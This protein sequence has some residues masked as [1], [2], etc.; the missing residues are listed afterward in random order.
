MINLIR[1]LWMFVCAC[2]FGSLLETLWCLIKERKIKKRKDLIYGYFTSMYGIAGVLIAICVEYFKINNVFIIFFISLV[3][4]AIVEYGSSFIQEKYMGTFSW[5]YSDMKFN[6]NGRINLVYLLVFGL[7]G[8]LWCK[9]Y[10]V[11]S[12]YLDNVINNREIVLIS[13]GI[14][15]LFMLYNVVISFIVGVRQKSRREGILPKNN[16]EIWI[17]N[18]Y[19]DQ[20][21]AKVFPTL[22]FV[23]EKQN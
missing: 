16:L 15:F 11:I 9:G 6:L 22:E 5:D 17:D 10:P 1:F 14:V 7:F 4:S 20:Y 23:D 12:S 2:F 18:K 13:S 21:I 8:V 19:N 3:I